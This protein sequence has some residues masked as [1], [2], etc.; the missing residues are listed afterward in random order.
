MGVLTGGDVLGALC[1]TL[2]FGALVDGFSIN[3]FDLTW[4][5]A[6]MV[7]GKKAH[8][9]VIK[10]STISNNCVQRSRVQGCDNRP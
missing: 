6:E 1:S 4:K 10:Q 8:S 7:L 5:R 2:S 9:P 3:L